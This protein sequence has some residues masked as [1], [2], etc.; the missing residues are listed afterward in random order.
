MIDPAPP[1]D[2]ESLCEE[3][4]DC[5]ES[6]Q[7]E[8]TYRALLLSVIRERLRASGKYSWSSEQWKVEARL[9]YI[10]ICCPT[11][12]IDLRECE[13]GK[14]MLVNGEPRTVAICKRPLSD[15][16]R[17]IHIEKREKPKAPPRMRFFELLPGGREW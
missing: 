17:W 15:D 14:G 8:K 5:D 1:S 12:G 11:C 7:Q 13:H 10:E 3:W 9:R 4:L 16:A 2:M 6:I